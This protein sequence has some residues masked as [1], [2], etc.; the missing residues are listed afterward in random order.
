[1]KVAEVELP[2]Y[3]VQPSEAEHYYG[4]IEYDD[5]SDS[6][7]I[8][9]EPIVCQFAKRLFPGA[10][11]RGPGIARFKSNKRTNGDLNWLMMRYP[12]QIKSRLMW[13]HCYSEAVKHVIKRNEINKLPQKIVPSP[14]YFNGELTEFQKEGV[15]YLVNNAPTLCADD[16][17][18]GKTIEALAWIASI[19]KFP[20]LIVVPT[21]VQK[22]WRSQIM[23][24]IVPQELSGQQSF[25]PD[26]KKQVHIIKGLT[27]YDLPEANFYIIHYG[28]L[29][30][31]KG[32]LPSFGFEFVVFDEIQELRH[33]NTDKYSSASLLAQS[34]GD[35]VVGLSGTPIYGKGIEIQ[36]VMNIIDYQCLGDR[37]SFTREWCSEYNGELVKDPEMLG[38]HLRRE[39]LMIRRTR[40]EVRS[41]MPPKRRIVQEIDSDEAAFSKEMKIILQMIGQHDDSEDHLEKGRLKRQIG[42][43]LRQ[44]T[45][46]SKAPYVANFVK[47]LL[48]AGES[49]VLY[50][51]HHEVYDIWRKE[52]SGY[53]PQFVT[54]HESEYQ[55]EIAK[56]VFI[57]GKSKLIII[58]LRAAAGIDGLQDAAFISVFGELDWAPGVHAQCEDRLDRMGQQEQ[59]LCYYL[60]CSEGSDEQMQEALGLKT[61]QF[62]GI[63][64]GKSENEEDK[65]LSQVEVGK[66]LDR[67]MDKLRSGGKA[68]V[69]RST[70]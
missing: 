63:M 24:F 12:L 28:L 5:K 46:V 44:A 30:G 3:L 21:S 18:L 66:H 26:E 62:I 70:V 17:G 22:Q 55:K 50:G 10:E 53:N 4:T 16:M 11:G 56:K 65:A 35:N 7:V 6:W 60:V 27:P 33:P 59:V 40:Q 29:R 45:G 38:Q 13:N 67:V 14:L 9:G 23:K 8:K 68:N 52:F 25:F 39:G 34:I 47:M 42:E 37:E 58:S 32:Y 2:S 57:E 43:K 61:A 41:E 19:A 1:M 64:G 20:G 31:W 15:A 69:I 48:D 49:V 54:G 36:S 51:W